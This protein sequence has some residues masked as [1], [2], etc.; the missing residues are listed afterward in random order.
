MYQLNTP[1]K[2]GISVVSMQNT[3]LSLVLDH[4]LYTNVGRQG[5]RSDDPEI[6]I[7]EGR[8]IKVLLYL[9]SIMLSSLDVLPLC[10][11]LV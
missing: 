11:V 2:L 4:A 5:F 8:V 7:I 9:D 1:K 6:W 3:V 10:S